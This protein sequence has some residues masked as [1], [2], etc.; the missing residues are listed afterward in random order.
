MYDKISKDPKE[1]SEYCSTFYCKLYALIN[2]LD[3][4]MCGQP[5]SLE[6]ITN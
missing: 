5:I 2:H 4:A 1:I 3:K 6:E